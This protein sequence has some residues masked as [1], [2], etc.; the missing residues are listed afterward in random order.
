MK[1]LQSYFEGEELFLAVGHCEQ[2]TWIRH[3]D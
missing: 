3:P 1:F 2:G